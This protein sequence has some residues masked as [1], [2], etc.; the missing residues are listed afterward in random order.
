MIEDEDPGWPI[1]WRTFAG[2]LLP[3]AGVRSQIK[4]AQGDGLVLLR[5]VF[6]SFSVA[7]LLFGI[8][9]VFLYPGLVP[10][11]EEPKPGIALALI[12]AGALA[13]VLER[14]LERPLACVDEQALADSYRTRFFLRIAMAESAAM[15]GFV[16]FF[17]SYEWWVYPAGVAITAIGFRRAAPTR[18]N[19]ANDQEHLYAQGCG[20]S[21]VGAVRRLTRQ[22]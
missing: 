3:G 12:A 15:F 4:A 11:G 10:K 17:V 7:L 19:L 2:L 5:Q 14:V 6:F 9:L 21:L 13:G 20:L 18:S 22:A 8:V 16:G 1:S